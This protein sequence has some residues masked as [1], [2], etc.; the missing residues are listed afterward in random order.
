MKNKLFTIGNRNII[1][2]LGYGRRLA[3]GFC[4]SPWAIDL[5]FGPWWLT[6]EWWRTNDFE[7]EE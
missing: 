1:F 7:T 2:I 4:I 6:I 3:L 5:E